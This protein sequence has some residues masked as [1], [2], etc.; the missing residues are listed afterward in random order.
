MRTVKRLGG[1]ITLVHGECLKVM[2]F[3]RDNMVD[4]VIC[5]PPYGTTA[6]KWDS[7]VDL[8]L[9]WDA[10]NRVAPDTAPVVLFAAQPFT[11]ALIMSNIRHY[12]YN[13]YWVKNNV[14]G[15]GYAKYQ[16]MRKTE[17]IAVFQRAT[18][19]YNPQG[20]VSLAKPKRGTNGKRR[21]QYA[22]GLSGMQA[23]SFVKTKTGYPNHLLHFD[24]LKKG[25]AVHATQKPVDLMEYLVRTYTNVGDTVL[26]FTMGSGT[27]GVACVNTGR[28]FIGIE[29]D[30]EH[31]YFDIAVERIDAAIASQDTD[32]L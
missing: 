20:V 31:G 11:S 1:D 9:M 25:T 24:N 17:D 14:T 27:T 26:D 21:G 12:K 5:D 28:K 13:W 22:K 19:V 23:K 2:G 18:G 8:P 7:V 10:L 16:P 6:C 3:M 15:F 32:A 30:T 4:A 29:Q